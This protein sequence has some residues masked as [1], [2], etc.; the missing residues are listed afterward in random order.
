[1]MPSC[2]QTGTFHFHSSTISGSAA[3]TTPRR[4]LSIAPRHPPSSWMRSSINCEGVPFCAT[5]R[6]YRRFSNERAP[7]RQRLLHGRANLRQAGLQV[8]VR[9]LRPVIPVEQFE[10][11]AAAEPVVAKV[12]QDLAEG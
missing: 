11:E 3:F 5:V 9:A 2:D 6:F 1:M 7:L 10:R 8:L 12:A 4:R